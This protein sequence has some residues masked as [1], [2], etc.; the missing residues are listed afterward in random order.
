MKTMQEI[1][2]TSNEQYR[3]TLLSR[4]R[5]DCAY[6]LGNG[7]RHVKYLWAG[8]VEDHIADMKMLWNSFKPDEK[9][10]WLTMADIESLEKRMKD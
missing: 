3:Y 2:E 9:P 10:E 8:N 5:A 1:I 7:N 6:Y 4:M